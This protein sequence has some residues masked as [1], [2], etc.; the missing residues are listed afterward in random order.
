[1]VTTHLSSGMQVWESWLK[2]KIQ[3]SIEMPV[4][5]TEYSQKHNLFRKDVLF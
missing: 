3:H 4:N 5:E 1:M 2:H